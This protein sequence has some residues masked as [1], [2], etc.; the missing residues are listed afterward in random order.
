M[1]RVGIQVRVLGQ[2]WGS[3]TRHRLGSGL[4]NTEQTSK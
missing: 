4:P 3:G 1:A 2:S